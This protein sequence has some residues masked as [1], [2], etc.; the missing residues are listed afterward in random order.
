[1]NPENINPKGAL[2]CALRSIT[3]S[4]MKLHKL[5][6]VFGMLLLVGGALISCKPTER[7]YQSAYEVARAKREAEKND[8]DMAL[9]L[10][11][12]RLDTSEGGSAVKT[13]NGS[14]LPQKALTLVFEDEMGGG[15]DWYVAVS[16][17][18]MPTNARAQ[19]YDMSAKGDTVTV[20]RDTDSQWYVIAARTAGRQAAGEAAERFI[21]KH[22]GFPFIGLDGAPLLIV[23]GSR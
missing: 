17:Y 6:A 16:R 7:N 10:G 4:S 23:S 2:R 11:G 5:I 12:H 18:S 19:A 1:M 22:P 3:L 21:A 13:D 14:Q 8:P 9:M 20:A 15:G